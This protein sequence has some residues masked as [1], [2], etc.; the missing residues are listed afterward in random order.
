MKKISDTNLDFISE[1]P[2]E[3]LIKKGSNSL[4][5]SELLAIL[6]RSGTKNESV[7]Q[8]A[9]HIMNDCQNSFNKLSNLSTDELINKYKGVGAA[10]ATTIQAV[11]EIIKRSI[12][13]NLNTN[14]QIT[15]CEDAF[16]Y[17]LPYLKN[18]EHEEFWILYLNR[19]NKVIATEKISQGGF[20]GTVTDIRII[21]RIGLEKRA[22]AFIA[23]HNHPSGNLKPSTDDIKT[24]ERIS[25]AGNIMNISLLDHLII[26][27]NTYY[28][29]AEHNYI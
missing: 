2:R 26:S 27:G 5:N 25:Q 3:K 10:K 19:A 14:S 29:F 22:S 23:A 4:N 9:K 16:Q 18:I 17:F 8:L 13:E 20:S 11:N 1:Q 6:L 28:S 21:L 7:H 24:T 12:S 15:S